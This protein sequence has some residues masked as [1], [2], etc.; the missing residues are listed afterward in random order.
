MAEYAFPSTEELAR[1][2]S[3]ALGDRNAVLLRNHGMVGV[4]RTS[5]EAL[6][7]CQMVERVAQI[8]VYTSLLGRALTL[9]PEIIEM[10]QE[11]YRMQGLRFG[12]PRET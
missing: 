10:E 1:N 6:D 4:G 7:I 5:W 11:L 12:T 3:H 2:A 9:P 8:F